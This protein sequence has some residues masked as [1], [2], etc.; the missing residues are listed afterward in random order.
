[1]IHVLY[2]D[3]EPDLLSIGKLF[4]EQTGEIRVDTSESG[5]AALGV[6]RTG[7]YD[8]IISDYLM[9]EM[10]GI[11][12]LKE[13]R[14]QFGTIPFILFTGRGREEV[15]VEALNNGAD[16]YLQ[17][18]GD[19][20]SQ[21]AELSSKIQLAVRRRRAEQAL[22]ESETRFRDLT[23]N[24][25]DTIMLFDKNLRHVYVNPNVKLQTGIPAPEFIGR[26]H[27]ELGFPP[28]LTALWQQTLRETFESGKNRRIEFAL[29]N[30]TWID[31]LLVPI[32]APDG[33]ITQVI[34]SAWDITDRKKAEDTLRLAS[35][36]VRASEEKLR[37]SYDEL[38]KSEK[39]ARENEENY[40]SL[41]ANIPGVV[42]HCANDPDWTI[43]YISP[44]I[45]TLS[46]YP[47]SDF[48]GN[49]VRS[50]ASI[51]HP[52]DRGLV[53]RSVQD[54]LQDKA[55]YS[56]EY[57]ILRADG[58]IRWV[59]ERGQGLFSEN[60]DLLWLNGVLLDQTGQKQ[61]ADALQK[62]EEQYRRLV[63]TTGTG[64]VILDTGGRVITANAEY[65]RLCGRSSLDEI[66]GRPVTDWTAPYDLERNAREM[67]TCVR[68]GSVRGLEI[69]YLKPDGSIQPV[70]INASTVSSES[71]L[72]ILALC[73]DIAGRIQSEEAL[74]TARNELELRVQERTA[75]LVLS[76]RRLS[77]LINH[78]PD[79]TFAIDPE[80]RVIAWNHAMEEMTGISLE[81]IQ[82]KGDHEYAIPFYGVRRPMLVDLVFASDEEFEKNYYHIIQKEG[83]V[84]VAESDLPRPLGKVSHLWGK[85]SPLYDETG[86]KI[87][88]IESIRDI[89]GWKRAETALRQSEDKYRA[90][91]ENSG[92]PLMIIDEDS[93]IVLVNREF[94]KLLGY[95][96]DEIMGKMSWTEFI[97]DE[98]DLAK[99]KEYHRLRRISADLAPV[100]YDSR[101]TNRK[102]DIRDV[103][104]TVVM[105]P[106]TRQSLAALID[107]TDR[108]RAEEALRRSEE[109]FRG[110]ASNLP[111][112]VYQ[113]YARDTGEWGMYFVSERSREVYGL[114][115]EPPD[116]WFN[117]FTSCIAPEDQDRWVGSIK[118]VIRRIAPWEFEGR[119]IKPS[120]EEMYIRGISQP[121]RLTNETV[122]NGILI[123]ITDRK[124]AEIALADAKDLA[125]NLIETAN[126]I[127]VGLDN[128]GRITIYNHETERI[129]GYTR[130]EMADRNWFE[131]IVPKDR[132]PYV[133][134]EFNRLM[135]GGLPK[136]FE[137]PILTKNGE[138]RYIAW[139][140]N[141]IREQG[142]IVGTISFGIDITDRKLAEDELRA[143][144]GE[145]EQRVLERTADLRRA[146]EAFRQANA[147]LNLLSSITRHDIL[148]Q[149]MALRGFLELTSLK[150]TDEAAARYVQKALRAAA[151]IE[152][153]ISF[154]K[155]YQD[156]GVKSPA[157]QNVRECAEKPVMDLL[158][159]SVTC[160]MELPQI[161]IY[162]DPLCE[163]VIYTLIDNS[164][165]HG[166]SVTRI[167]LFARVLETGGLVLQY[168]DNGAGIP[169]EDKERIFERGFGKHT[170]FG[171]FLAR[172]ILAI[173]GITITE[174][175]EP[176]NGARFEMVVPEGAYRFGGNEK[177]G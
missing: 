114:A 121:V 54:G 141:E 130:E 101:V 31:W 109:R 28:D 132:F 70:E 173:T 26:T 164:L 10:D 85:A 111:G 83:D 29:P 154:T 146:E 61:A 131:T 172:E 149:L 73:R 127:I 64:Y 135:T 166:G 94:E 159:A 139:K 78:L 96:R 22:Q 153:H 147:K 98:P 133:H 91:F 47:A 71:G 118:D 52:D 163:K 44:A 143:L 97:A 60:G 1:M 69:D 67:E 128:D 108:K 157:W 105:I 13:V 5:N 177:T 19:P 2:V 3:D 72:H 162:A 81:Q 156:I 134:D 27:A 32:H 59:H 55:I 126:A 171:L 129:T 63:E 116:T 93:T 38:A 15:V 152:R 137:N 110:I 37:S 167:R 136:H 84:I 115:A 9:P 175:G 4:L 20:R 25:L 144:Y 18:G 33:S 88:A 151:T 124:K 12:F 62:S 30:G 66:L 170:G 23:E 39:R 145:L 16:F 90:L 148:N 40:R 58:S 92:S 107:I 7:G 51:I 43:Q 17:K 53:T 42:Y 86:A 103:I 100:T 79:A 158:P 76:E 99:M 117:R 6:L 112:I 161:E 24:S 50:Y 142:K 14:Q 46:G 125:E 80:G 104:I 87:G 74:R 82:G 48:I 56:M 35:D 65:L 45:L 75:A 36:Q 160:T 122:W 95:P 113:F 77:D 138:L 140:N 106:A 150:E 119:F 102:G 123:D 168:T 176:G 49:A 41:V 165:R 8:A 11:A 174:T 68:A 34:T 21:F 169:A 57:R 89:T 155:Q 120:G